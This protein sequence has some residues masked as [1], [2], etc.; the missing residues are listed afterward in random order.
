MKQG[1][2]QKVSQ[3]LENQT[4]KGKRKALLR[5]RNVIA[6][7][8]AILVLVCVVIVSTN[9]KASNFIKK[10][11][12]QI[13]QTLT[14]TRA[15][16]YIK[17]VYITS[18]RD[19]ISV[20]DGDYGTLEVHVITN[21]GQDLGE[22]GTV[23]YSTVS[24]NLGDVEINGNKV[25][26]TH[27][28]TVRIQATV[29]Y[30]GETVTSNEITITIEDNWEVAYRDA[31]FFKYDPDELFEYGGRVVD[32]T[33]QGL[34]F[35]EGATTTTLG[36]YKFTTSDWNRWTKNVRSI[37]DPELPYS[38]LVENELDENGNIQFKVED[39]GIFDENIEEGKDS[40]TNVGLPF[41]KQG[42]GFYKFDS[43]QFEAYFENGIPKS[44]V[45]LAWSDE[46]VKYY[47]DG[48][49]AI[50]G[51][52]PFNSG[53][54]YKDA[55]YHFGMKIHT[56]FYMTENGQTSTGEDITF[57]F[58][59][60]DDIWIFIDGKLVIDIGGIHN[61][62][63]A[64]INFANNEVILYKG[65]KE[66]G[67]VNTRTNL[68]DILGSDWNSDTEKEHTLSVFYLERGKG[69]S[70]CQVYFNLPTKVQQSDVIV[71]HYKE[72]TKEK[73]APDEIIEGFPGDEYTTSPSSEVPANCELVST[74]DNATG[75]IGTERTEVIYYYSYEEGVISNNTVTKTS[76]LSEI[77][78]VT[79][80]STIYY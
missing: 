29:Q 55:I 32:T 57:E 43:T 15:S 56:P 45:D 18:T 48:G 66:N 5:P 28:G 6:F 13:G 21:D 42:N 37:G 59:G 79:A 39:N 27:I 31:T 51:F 14:E 12:T 38:G 8:I 36:D 75:I 62:I 47:S 60:D 78:D 23:A 77:D 34:Y 68:T 54:N 26:G 52:F 71:H 9:E 64:D 19:V 50:K 22:V 70:N 30:D 53:V 7:I 80:R 3:N 2:D 63:S 74:P 49:S 73:L 17:R 20:K 41:V 1:K 65:L 4:E 25:T 67:V 76:S 44:D 24:E 61:Q 35:T 40:Y 11:I 58:S 72:G 69:S 10:G 46:K 33:S 16:G